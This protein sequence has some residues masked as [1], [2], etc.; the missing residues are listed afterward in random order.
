VRFDPT[1]V[2][3]TPDVAPAVLARP[4]RSAVVPPALCSA[5]VTA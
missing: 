4:D 2:L 3:I 5:T 1:L